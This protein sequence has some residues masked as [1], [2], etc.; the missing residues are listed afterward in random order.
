MQ[1]SFN[2][3]IQIN[4]NNSFSEMLSVSQVQRSLGPATNPQIFWALIRS[5]IFSLTFYCHFYLFWYYLF[6]CSLIFFLNQN[7]FYLLNHF[8]LYSSPFWAGHHNTMLLMLWAYL[9]Q[10]AISLPH[11][12]QNRGR[13][14]SLGEKTRPCMAAKGVTALMLC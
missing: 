6:I 2:S 14:C 3:V 8:K 10:Q 13:K 1:S 12:R 7:K 5:Q 9:A 11:H 4:R